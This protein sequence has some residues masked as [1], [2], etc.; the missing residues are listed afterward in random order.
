MEK[1]IKLTPDYLEYY[2]SIEKKILLD[3]FKGGPK[4]TRIIIRDHDTG[5]VLGDL[6]NKVVITG[7]IFSAMNAFGV[8]TPVVLPSYNTELELDN[9]LDYSTG[10][11][12]NQPIVCL[13]C[14][15]DSGCGATQK[16]V[17]KANFTDRIEPLNDII[18]FK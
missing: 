10:E 2:D 8:E 5:E 7:S 16:D 17:Y 11:K 12:L 3:K 4:R 15:G 9:T 14:V 1:V 13:F 18:P 6:E